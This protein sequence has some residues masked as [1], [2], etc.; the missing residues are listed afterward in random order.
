MENREQL[1]DVR[2][3]SKKSRMHQSDVEKALQQ[4]R[5]RVAQLESA[6]QQE[7]VP[8]MKWKMGLLSRKGNSF[9]GREEEGFTSGSGS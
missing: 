1:R 5:K 6:A 2:P 4:A 3:A 8:K 9:E 7:S